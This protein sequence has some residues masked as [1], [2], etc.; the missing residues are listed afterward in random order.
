MKEAEDSS[1]GISKRDGKGAGSKNGASEK[2]R[3]SD[4][5]IL[6]TIS[7]KENG[8]PVPFQDKLGCLNSAN[9]KKKCS[10]DT[11]NIG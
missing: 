9:Q 11:V 6:S 10:A 7:V 3:L 8:E 2:R 4:K 5:L 1:L